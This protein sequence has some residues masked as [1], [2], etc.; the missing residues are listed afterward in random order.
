MVFVC[1]VAFHVVHFPL[2]QRWFRFVVFVFRTQPE[3]LPFQRGHTVAATAVWK[4]LCAGNSPR[5]GTRRT[6]SDSAL[7]R[8]LSSPICIQNLDISALLYKSRSCG[9]DIMSVKTDSKFESETSQF[10]RFDRNTTAVPGPSFA[11]FISYLICCSPDCRRKCFW[12]VC[13][14]GSE[15]NCSS[16]NLQ[17]FPEQEELLMA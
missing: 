6:K 2:L 4:R 16:Q 17:T 1:N 5:H 7:S 11:K 13:T 9:L 14:S 3:T 15:I 12:R 10:R 8:S